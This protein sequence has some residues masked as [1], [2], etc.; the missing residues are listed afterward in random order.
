MRW[1]FFFFSR[2]PENCDVLLGKYKELNE[3]LNKMMNRAYKQRPDCKDILTKKDSW[4]LNK[5]NFNS[6]EINKIDRIILEKTNQQNGN[7]P[8]LVYSI[9]RSKLKGVK[10]SELKRSEV[11]NTLDS[12][13]FHPISS[14]LMGFI[15][16]FER[17]RAGS[18]CL[19][20]INRIK[21]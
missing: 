14:I 19:L 9:L 18:W 12:L 3:W 20:K 7:N 16:W 10:R 13:N 2:Y 21:K 6:S 4:A 1:N 15:Y 8:S 11:T 5:Q 17:S